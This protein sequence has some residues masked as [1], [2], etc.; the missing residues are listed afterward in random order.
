MQ[1]L[2]VHVLTC[3]AVSRTHGTTVLLQLLQPKPK[4]WVHVRV[5]GRLA[6][7]DLGLGLL[8][9]LVQARHH[10]DDRGHSKVVDRLAVHLGKHKN[11]GINFS[12]LPFPA[13]H[14]VKTRH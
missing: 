7:R 4:L 1:G 12:L 10:G 2:G 11:Q 8:P 9:G 5:H 3:S 14:P 6:D 13:P